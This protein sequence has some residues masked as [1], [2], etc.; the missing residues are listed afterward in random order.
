MRRWLVIC[1]TLIVTLAAIPMVSAQEDLELPELY[2]RVSP[3][4][5]FIE[6]RTQG[7]DFLFPTDGLGS[8]F[9][10]DT[11]G[12]IVTNYHVVQ[13]AEAINVTFFDGTLARAEVVGLDADSDLAVIRVQ[14]V[15][16]DRLIPVVLGDSSAVRIGEEVV[17]I[18]NP[19]GQT[20]TMTRGIIS[21]LGRANR[22][23]TGF[24]IPQMIQTDAA[25]NPGNSGGPLVNHAGEVIGVNTMIFSEEG[26]SAGVGFAVPSNTVRRVVPELI[27]NGRYEYTWIG[28]SG[29]DLSLDLIELLQLD[30]D[31]RGVLVSRVSNN[32]PADEAGLRGSNQRAQINGLTYQIG[33]DIIIALNDTPITS[34]NDLIAFLAENTRPGDQVTVTLIRDNEV[35]QVPVTLEARPDQAQ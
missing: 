23:E 26:R 20:W 35:I 17:A 25:I 13:D 18:G 29:G 12:H 31:T 1:L 9:V 21:A 24:S 33:G 6:V 30:R 15:P 7:G 3:S 27:A 4:V 11:D 19:F 22:A 10:Y 32:S 28:I 16:K 34:I 2:E 8:G 5:V 14:D